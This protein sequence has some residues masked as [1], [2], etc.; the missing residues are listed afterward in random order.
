MGRHFDFFATKQDALDLLL[1]LERKSPLV[2]VRWGYYPTPEA[3]TYA[4]A[5]ELPD[6]GSPTQPRKGG[7]RYIVFPQSVCIDFRQ[8]SRNGGE[9]DF[10]T[11]PPDGMPWVWFSSG[12]QWKD[13]C[14]ITGAVETG[15]SDAVGLRFFDRFPRAIRSQFTRV[16]RPK[17]ADCVGRIS[18]IGPEALELLRGG[19]RFTDSISSPRVLDFRLYHDLKPE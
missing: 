19:M 10:V 1:G 18:Y 11:T 16:E 2:F 12:G 6:L 7:N 8:V 17:L 15:M 9:T 4:T 13:E 14:L 5:A 3:P